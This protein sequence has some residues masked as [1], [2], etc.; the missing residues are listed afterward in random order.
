MDS[1][2][3]DHGTGSSS[4]DGNRNGNRNDRNATD[5]GRIAQDTV[6][7]AE[8]LETVSRV[9][10]GDEP[11]E[12]SFW[13]EYREALMDLVRDLDEVRRR[14]TLSIGHL[15][16]FGVALLQISAM[17]VI[18]ETDL[19]VSV[20]GVQELLEAMIQSWQRNSTP[21]AFRGATENAISALP[22]IKLDASKLDSNGE[23]ACAICMESLSS[24]DEVTELPCQHWFCGDCIC[25]WL[26]EHDSCPQCRR[27]MPA[28]SRGGPSDTNRSQPPPP[29]LDLETLQL[30]VPT[31]D[32]PPT[33]TDFH[34][35][36]CTVFWFFNGLL[37]AEDEESLRQAQ[38]RRRDPADFETGPIPHPL[39]VHMNNLNI[40]L[41]VQRVRR[42]LP[43]WIVRQLERLRTR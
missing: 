39:N 29:S 24:G 6:P 28:I 14:R 38:R 27:I 17:R 15:R 16:L 19:A 11:L 36:R 9:P 23:T 8:V 25:T 7:N 20:D 4:R 13:N 30:P 22:K 2:D 31:Q 32:A 37:T 10:T 41:G 5:G 21:L 3:I 18:A 42:S 43:L 35:P 33:R 34:L 40:I 1:F 26:R 12:P